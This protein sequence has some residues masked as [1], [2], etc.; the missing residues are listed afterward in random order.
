MAVSKVELERRISRFAEACRR[1][2]MKVTHQRTEIFREVAGSDEHPDA[3]TVYRRVRKRVN[4]ISRDTVYRTLATLE[5]EG[6][7]RKAEVLGPSARFDANLYQHHH[8]VCTVCGAVKDFRSEAL[9]DLPIPD[10]VK[11]LGSIESAQVHVRGVCRKCQAG[12]R[13]RKTH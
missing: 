3:E 5:D 9:D 4:G 6:L 10:A 2:G 13:E 7:I 1:S 11:G 12:A 8:F